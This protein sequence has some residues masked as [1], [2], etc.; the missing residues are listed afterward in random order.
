VRTRIARDVHDQLGSDLTKLVMLSSEVKAVALEDPA[1]L[2]RT[3]EHIERVAGEANR[4]LGD[5]V[6][7]IDPD[8]DSLA[9]LTERVRAHVERMLTWSKVAY[10]VDCTHEGPDRTLDPATK[11]DVYLI[12][13]EALNNALKHAKASHIGVTFRT[14]PVH[15]HMEVKDNGIGFIMRARAERIGGNLSITSTNGTTV[16]FDLALHT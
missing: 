9:G 3:A 12:L 13:R 7:A 8:H 1:E 14:S 16:C 6:W 5:I 4:S 11:R 10:T 15:V 2:V